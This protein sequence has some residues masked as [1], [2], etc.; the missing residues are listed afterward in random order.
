[1]AVAGARGE[2]DSPMCRLAARRSALLPTA[3][4]HGRLD[5]VC[6][7]HNAWKIHKLMNGSRL[8]LVDHAGHDPYHADMIAALVSATDVFATRGNFSSLGSEWIT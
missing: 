3:I 8:R 1:M 4:V 2:G 7:P 5:W 6:R